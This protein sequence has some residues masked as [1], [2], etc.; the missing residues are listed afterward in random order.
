MKI[1]AGLPIIFFA[2]TWSMELPDQCGAL[3]H[4]ISPARRKALAAVRAEFAIPQPRWA[5]FTAIIKKLAKQHK[6]R[7]HA[8]VQ[9]VE[10]WKECQEKQC[11]MALLHKAISPKECAI[12]KMIIAAFAQR[13]VTPSCL[14]LETI[15]IPNKT[16]QTTEKVAYKISV[17]GR[18]RLDELSANLEWLERKVT[19]QMNLHTL[20]RF[21]PNF[22]SLAAQHEAGHYVNIDCITSSLLDE[23][24]REQNICQDQID[25][26]SSWNQLKEL[27]EKEADDFM[28]NNDPKRIAL[29]K[30]YCVTPGHWNFNLE[31]LLFQAC[32]NNSKTDVEDLIADGVMVNCKSSDQHTAL[33]VACYHGHDEIIKILF[34]AGANSDTRTNKGETPLHHACHTGKHTT[35]KLLLEAYHTDPNTRMHGGITPLMLAAYHGHMEIIESL[36]AAGANLHARADNTWRA[37]HFACNNKKNEASKRLQAQESGLSGLWARLWD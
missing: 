12:Y 11:E 26:S 10:K 23:L 37:Y 18:Q 29:A 34:A 22:I 6:N 24:I 31:I 28:I 17:P 3:A 14:K 30:K 13:K 4:Y 15:D 33:H 27:M 16:I 21:V 8:A 9:E 2:F 25:Q 1:L 35:V 19:I 20:E 7:E 36:L 32:K 5:A